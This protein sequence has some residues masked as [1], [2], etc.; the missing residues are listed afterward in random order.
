MGNCYP[1]LQNILI[2]SAYTKSR[3]ALILLVYMGWTTTFAGGSSTHAT[4]FL[5]NL[6]Y[7]PKVLVF[8][9]LLNDMG[10]RRQVWIH[11][12]QPLEE[13]NAIFFIIILLNFSFKCSYG[14]DFLKVK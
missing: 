5:R 8:S 3:V 7:T 12:K 11:R 14:Y 4:C 9:S 6:N 10:Y 2:F 13:R 1:H